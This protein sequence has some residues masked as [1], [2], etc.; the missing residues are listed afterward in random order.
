M[1]AQIGKMEK[2]QGPFIVYEHVLFI[3]EEKSRNWLKI[4]QEQVGCK[5]ASAVGRS[6]SDNACVCK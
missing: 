2:T 6:L 5:S 3:R 1:N 4:K